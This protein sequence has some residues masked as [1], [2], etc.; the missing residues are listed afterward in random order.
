[1]PKIGANPTLLGRANALARVET[2]KDLERGKNQKNQPLR[3][4]D[5]LNTLIDYRFYPERLIPKKMFRVLDGDCGKNSRSNRTKAA[6]VILE[7]DTY[8]HP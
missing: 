2:V 8:S 6:S 7:S 1:V 5:R 3:K 4:L